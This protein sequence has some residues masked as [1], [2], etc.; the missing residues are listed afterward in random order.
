MSKISFF[1]ED[2]QFAIPQKKILNEWIKQVIIA[3]N[4]KLIAISYVFC[5]DEYLHQMNLDYLQHDTL[6]DIITFDQSDEES[7]IEGDIFI[8]VP[9]VFDNATDLNLPFEDELLRVLIHGVL[10]LCGFEDETD[11]EE[12]EMRRKENICIALFKE[13]IEDKEK[14]FIVKISNAFL[15]DLKK[16]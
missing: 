3:E 16:K 13:K 2:F 8:S 15:D 7:Q 9:R 10:H 6:T 4:K 14:P 5:S 12:A 1:C 11:E